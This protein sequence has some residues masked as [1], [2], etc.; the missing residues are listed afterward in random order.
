M[1]FQVFVLED[2]VFTNESHPGPALNRMY[3]AGAIPSTYKTFFYEMTR[4][5]DRD[6][7]PEAWKERLSAFVDRLESPDKLVPWEPKQ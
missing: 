1:G 4:T 3:Q 5:V 6:A 2:C 7:A